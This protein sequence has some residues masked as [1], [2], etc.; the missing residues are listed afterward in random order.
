[1]GDKQVRRGEKFQTQDWNDLKKMK[2]YNN[3]HI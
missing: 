3:M 1:M 2:Y